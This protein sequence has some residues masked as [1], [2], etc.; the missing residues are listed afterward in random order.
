MGISKIM[1]TK[2]ITT[3]EYHLIEKR[4]I[5]IYF[6]FSFSCVCTRFLSHR[7]FFLQ[8]NWGYFGSDLTI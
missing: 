6:F 2:F 1:K 3:N 5:S 8:F 4:N 7:D